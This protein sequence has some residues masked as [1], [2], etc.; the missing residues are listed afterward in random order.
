MGITFIST[1]ELT[2]VTAMWYILGREHTF[3]N[4][5]GLGLTPQQ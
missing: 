1:N 5:V 3:S 4:I 2:S